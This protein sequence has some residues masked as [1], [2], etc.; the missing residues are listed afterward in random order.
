M[1]AEVLALRELMP[2]DEQ[3]A[4]KDGYED[5]KVRGKGSKKQ[6]KASKKRVSKKKRSPVAAK[7][8]ASRRT[9]NAPVAQ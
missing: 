8:A 2:P 1:T 3:R 4:D 7:K 6:N 5:K 9:K